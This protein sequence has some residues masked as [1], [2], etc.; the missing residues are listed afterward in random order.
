M[1]TAKSMDDALELIVN[2]HDQLACLFRQVNVPDTDHRTVL[3]EL[4]K[5]MAAHVAV[6]QSVVVPVL[7]R[8]GRKGKDLSRSLTRHYRRIEHL[9]VLIERRKID[10]P[11][12]PA[13]VSDLR[14]IFTS[15]TEFWKSCVHPK[16]AMKLSMQADTTLVVAEVTAGD[17]VGTGWTYGT[18]GCRAVI[19]DEPS[20]ALVGR[21]PFR[22]GF[23]TYDDDHTAGQIEHWVAELHT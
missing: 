3:A 7:K 11:D 10:S 18:S 16:L 13:M 19:E 8:T 6:E 20:S 12:L 17:G 9:L 21:D 4:V 2:R 23:T 14:D 15:H 22:S 1:G 5:E